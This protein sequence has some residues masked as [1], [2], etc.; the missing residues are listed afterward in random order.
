VIAAAIA[1]LFGLGY[2]MNGWTGDSFTRTES[3]K[4]LFWPV[5]SFME[6]VRLLNTLI[7]GPDVQARAEQAEADEVEKR[8]DERR[9]RR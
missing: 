1:Y 7:V 3:A 4:L 9:W 5:G 2:Y 8:E 6:F